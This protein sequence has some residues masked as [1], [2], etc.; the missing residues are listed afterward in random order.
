MSRS[1]WIW[2]LGLLA[3]CFVLWMCLNLHLEGLL[4]K[5][6]AAAMAPALGPAQVSL[7]RVGSEVLV[8]GL[9]RSRD[10][11]EQVLASVRSAA[12]AQ[13]Q[14]VD[15]LFESPEVG[16]LASRFVPL[17]SRFFPMGR[18]LYFGANQLRFIGK[19]PS[20]EAKAALEAD[21]GKASSGLTVN[22]QV[23]VEA[24]QTQV[25]QQEVDDI[26]KGTV[27]EFQTASAVIRPSSFK[28]L[29][30]I[31]AK[32][33]QYPEVRVKI[34]GH[35][36]SLGAA[37]A[38][39]KLSQN[40]ADS[41]RNAMAQRGIAASRIESTGYGSTRPLVPETSPENRAKNRRIELVIVK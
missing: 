31:A 32:L 19:A 23:S 38:N 27:I 30:S 28:V 34:D 12:G 35:T 40:R 13:I 10:E 14:V 4:P 24:S 17:S 1:V 18:E 11:H 37:S 33:K 21:I 41:V 22:T 3:F 36:D 2:F 15:R 16:P 39:M 29:D 8:S 6:A 26:L 7:T 25:L 5:T 20:P 9:V